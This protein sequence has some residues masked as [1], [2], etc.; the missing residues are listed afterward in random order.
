MSLAFSDTSLKS[1]DCFVGILAHYASTGR[2]AALHA[3]LLQGPG[4][5][6]A[7]LKLKFTPNEEKRHTGVIR[8]EWQHDILSDTSLSDDI[9]AIAFEIVYEYPPQTLADDDKGSSRDMSN[10]EFGLEDVIC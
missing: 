4:S 3:Y 1:W 6:G 8:L 10:Q 7:F 9:G 5:D 2:A